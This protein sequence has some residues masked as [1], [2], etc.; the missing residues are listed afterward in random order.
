MAWV[1][2]EPQAHAPRRRWKTT[3]MGATATTVVCVIPAFLVG[4]LAVQIGNE[5]GF[6][7][8][9]L[10]LAVSI[11]FGVSALASVPAG[12]LVERFGAV[13][14]ARAGIIISASSLEAIAAFARN[15]ATLVA[16][17]AVAG[18]ANSLGQLASNAALAAQ[19]PKA[20]QGFSFGV[21]QAAIPLST[22]L[23]GFAVPVVALTFGWRWAFVVAAILAS[24]ALFLVP[25]DGHGRRRRVTET[26]SRRATVALV[27]VG[28]AVALAAGSANT[29][30]V[31]LV[32]A[33]V[34]D[35][36]EPGMAGL[37]LSFGS[38]LCVGA[39]LLAGLLA[40]RRASGHLLAV[41]GMLV[42]GAVG[43]WLLT[44]PGPL[45]MT[46]A[47]MLGFG[48]GWSWPGLLNF[49]VV[50][51]YPQTPAAATSVTQ[52]GVYA[53]SCLGPFVFGTVAAAYGYPAAWLGASEAML[54]AAAIL[55]LSRNPAS[56]LNP[57]R[58]G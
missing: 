9:R 15:Y 54:L 57:G 41:A 43:L 25:K 48:F 58:R 28:V 45:I 42:V 19:V 21:K 30:G 53:G 38:T 49:A 29:M 20:R 52:T 44:Q 47:I 31:F 11:Y 55:I 40:D 8:A 3:V 16:L 1:L 7:P 50:Q 17:L 35:G 46:I 26:R 56:D 23:A 32:D 13:G 37:A 22:L 14:T 2:V 12:A 39:R 34:A 27:V 33:A 5:L 36:I 24:T 10:G 51:L 6:N 18:L 4:G